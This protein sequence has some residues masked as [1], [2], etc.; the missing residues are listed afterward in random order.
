MKKSRI[1]IVVAFVFLGLLLL[2]RVRAH[3]APVAPAPVVEEERVASSPAVA[4]RLAGPTPAALPPAGPVVEAISVEKTEVCSGEDNLATVRLAGGY[5]NDPNIRIMMPSLGVAGAQMPFQLHLNRDNM[6]PPEMPEVVVFSR[7]GILAT[8]KIPPVTVKD[9]TPGPSLVIE[10]TIVPNTSA[11]YVFTATV[12]NSG[13]TPFQPVEWRWDFGDGADDTTKTR[14][15]EH[16]YEDRPQKTRI[17][18]FLIHVRAVD[19]QGVE[20]LGRYGLEMRNRAYEALQVKNAILLS[21]E[22]NPRFPV[23]SADGRVTERVRIHHAYDKPVTI[24]K[25]FMQRFRHNQQGREEIQ[26]VEVDP[27]QILGTNVIPPGP[28]IEAVATLDTRAE[29][30]TGLLT[31]DLRGRSI[32][33]IRASGQFSVMRPPELI[34]REQREIITDPVLKAEILEAR[35]LL[36]RDQVNDDDL[37]RLE[38]EGAFDNLRVA[39][40]M[41]AAS[42]DKGKDKEELRQLPKQPKPQLGALAQVPSSAPPGAPAHAPSSAAP[43]GAPTQAPSTPPDVL[44][45]APSAPPGAPAKAPSAP[46]PPMH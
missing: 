32:D 21:T 14:T 45:Q 9:C 20:V 46:P 7:D 22:L 38:R 11:T 10:A 36:G 26:E 24:Q 43:P 29:V 33:G 16:S 34:P 19:A 1:G 42:Q 40:T 12:R 25:V 2:F 3:H 17:S 41:P 18:A 27:G 44:A 39:A 6:Q 35:K 37:M 13:P 28:G 15:V 4:P 8:V 30:G 31:F 23:M 5:V